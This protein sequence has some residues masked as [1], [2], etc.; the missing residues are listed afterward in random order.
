MKKNKSIDKVIIADIK[1]VKQAYKKN[2]EDNAQNAL[3]KIKEALYDERII[4]SL[5]GEEASKKFEETLN[6]LKKELPK[7]AYKE[8]Q[9]YLE[10]M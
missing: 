8:I 10:Y 4:A 6:Y 7:E 1:I 2:Q 5:E 9:D 3:Q